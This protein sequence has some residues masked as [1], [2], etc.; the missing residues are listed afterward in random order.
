MRVFGREDNGFEQ[1]KPSTKMKKL[2][3]STATLCVGNFI[4]VSSLFTAIYPSFSR[5]LSH[6][7]GKHL[8]FLSVIGIFAMFMKIVPIGKC[9]SDDRR[10]GIHQTGIRAIAATSF[11]VLTFST[12]FSGQSRHVPPRQHDQS[13]FC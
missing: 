12:A 6:S 11:N 10:F 4:A 3:L 9:S 7:C 2:H 13:F 8:S 5:H 1:D